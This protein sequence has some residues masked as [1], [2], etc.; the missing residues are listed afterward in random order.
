[1]NEVVEARE[2]GADFAVYGP[3]FQTPGKT[4]PQGGKGLEDLSDVCSAANRFPVVALGG[5]DVSN[6]RLAIK[7]GAFGIAGIRMFGDPGTAVGMIEDLN[8]KK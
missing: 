2:S 1:L 6:Y 8:R 4:G 5:V 7:A 3:V